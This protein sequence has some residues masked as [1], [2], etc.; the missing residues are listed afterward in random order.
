MLLLQ[1]TDYDDDD[2]IRDIDPFHI[3]STTCLTPTASIDSIVSTTTRHR[4]LC[5]LV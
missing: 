5:R 3:E 1:E 2:R 4:P